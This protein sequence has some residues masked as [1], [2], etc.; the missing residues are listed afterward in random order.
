MY[1]FIYNFIVDQVE[2][3]KTRTLYRPP[4]VG[5]ARADNPGL[6]QLKQ[7]V[8]PSHLRPQD[9]LPEAQAVVAFFIPFTEALIQLHRK[10]AYISREWAEAYIETNQLI[11]QICTA[12]VE[13]LQ[14]KGVQAA[15]QPATH[16]FDTKTLASYWSHKHVAYWCGLGT[17]GLHQMLITPSGC[18]GRLGSLV[19][20]C[21]MPAT[22]V[23]Q[24]DFCLYRGEQKCAACTRLCPTGALTK[25]GLD[26]ARCY[27][28]LLEVNAYYA[29]L[30]L[31]DVC[32]KCA[33]GPC[34]LRAPTIKKGKA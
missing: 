22:P 3:A 10:E 15:W 16:N 5:V 4:L 9:L 14:K 12:L 26:K 19:L 32:G 1:Q 6:A 24:Q 29:D 33:V 7:I 30:G 18:A 2:Q 34:A 27:Q 11:S 13:A 23:W 8:G 20:D 17:F 28:H 31:C 25:D 21:A